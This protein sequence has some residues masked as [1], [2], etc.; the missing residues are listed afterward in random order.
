MG[1]KEAAV[2]GEPW[3]RAYHHSFVGNAGNEGSFVWSG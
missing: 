1:V 2:V 3:L